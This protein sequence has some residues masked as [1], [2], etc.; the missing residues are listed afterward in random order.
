MKIFRYLLL[1]VIV[2][3]TACAENAFLNEAL[4]LFQDGKVDQKSKDRLLGNLIKN[5][6]ETHHFSRKVIDDQRSKDAFGLYVKRLDYRKRFFLKSDIDQLAKYKTAIDDQILTGHIAINDRSTQ[7]YRKRIAEIAKF[8]DEELKKKIDFSKKE[9][10][11]LEPK[12]RKFCKDKKELFALWGKILKLDVLTR[13][14][15]LQSEQDGT[16][17]KDKKKKKAKLAKKNK[18]KK[19]T[20]AQIEEKA[21]KKTKKSYAKVFKRMLQ[22]DHS[23]YISKLMNSITMTFDPHTT[24]LPPKVKENFNIDIKGS[25]EGIGAL[26]RE[27]EDYIKVVEIVPGSASWR[28]GELKADDVILKVVPNPQGKKKSDRDEIDLVGMRVDDAVQYIR[29]KKGSQV[30]LTVK[31]PHGEVVYITIIRDTVVI[32]E[33][34]VKSAIVNDKKKGK[35]I[36]YIV[37]PKFYRDFTKSADDPSARDC[38][39][40]VRNELVKFKK[41]GVDG[42]ILDLRNNGGGSLEDAIIMSGLFIKKGPIV[43]IKYSDGKMS[44]LQDTDPT[45]EYDG[46]L[47]VLQNSYS[48]SASEIV[49]GALQDYGR[50]VVI[51]GKKSHG[52]GTVQTLVELDRGLMRFSKNSNQLGTL[53]LTISK[54]YR[55]SGGST[56][57]KGVIPDIIVPD[58]YSYLD[59]GESSLDFSL[60]WDEVQTATYKKWDRAHYKMK[61]L[62]A[63]S[64]NRVSKSP[65]FGKI[66][67]TVALLEKRRKQTLVSLNIEETKKDNK[68]YKK[69]AEELKYDEDE[70]ENLEISYKHLPPVIK[71]ID[72]KMAEANKEKRDEFTKSLRVDPYITEAINVLTDM[73]SKGMVAESKSKGW[74]KK[75]FQ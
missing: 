10:I 75:L 66:K 29:G 59:S 37:V 43:Q 20:Y 44:V 49:A 3:S 51:G 35:K 65:K 11:E 71:K 9:Y 16:K 54:F 1:L 52:K 69:L 5:R 50:A 55:V 39:S 61:T 34:Y 27:D 45:V 4:L 63:N 56:Q 24:Y 58:P 47:V 72:K 38:S 31:K 68:V 8:V 23:D 6:L 22:E 46:E 40:D 13:V 48:A 15:D 21:R 28:Q 53:K 25:L 36:G 67:R 33:T 26:L 30:L 62:V 64:Q 74:F 42:V 70:N 73:R 18:Q 2:S 57:Y 19:L 7:I 17:K 14:L 60:P 41:V 32:A 12:K